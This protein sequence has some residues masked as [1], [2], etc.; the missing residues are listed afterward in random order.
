MRHASKAGRL[1]AAVTGKQLPDEYYEWKGELRCR[2]HYVQVGADCCAKC[3][4][5]V[6]G[7]T[8]EGAG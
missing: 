7:G 4:E 6:D 8:P 5:P 1:L 2:E 3:G